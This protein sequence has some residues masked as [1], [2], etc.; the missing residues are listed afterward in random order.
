VLAAW[1][2][3]PF[4]R[5]FVASI[6][7]LA[8]CSAMREDKDSDDC[9]GD[10]SYDQCPHKI[11]YGSCGVFSWA[12]SLRVVL[13]VLAING[14]LPYLALHLGFSPGITKHTDARLLIHALPECNANQT[15]G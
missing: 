9:Q 12:R 3:T 14:G 7:H 1:A 6:R 4:A 8:A 15:G 10:E 5:L 2:L 13:R 11:L